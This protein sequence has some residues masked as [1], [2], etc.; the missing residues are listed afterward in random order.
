MGYLVRLILMK[1]TAT[2]NIHY[3]LHIKIKK[4]SADEINRSPTIQM[5]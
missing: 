4:E 1:R 2:V 5:A 3:E